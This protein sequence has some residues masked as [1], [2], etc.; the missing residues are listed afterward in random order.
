MDVGRHQS[1]PQPSGTWWHIASTNDKIASEV[2]MPAYEFNL[3]C[4]PRPKRFLISRKMVFN[5]LEEQLQ[6]ILKKMNHDLSLGP[7]DL[8]TFV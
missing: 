1:L 2:A 3:C 7:R 4:K 5:P 8:H 6:R